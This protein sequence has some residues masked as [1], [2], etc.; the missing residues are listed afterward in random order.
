MRRTADIKLVSEPCVDREEHMARIAQ[1]E[2]DLHELKG[3]LNLSERR[4]Y[5]ADSRY[6]VQSGEF[7]SLKCSIAN[8]RLCSEETVQLLAN[9]FKDVDASIDDFIRHAAHVQK[10]D[11]DT[12]QD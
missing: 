5:V 4:K 1:S 9:A 6:S 11:Q 8:G 7:D 3:N 10:A 12:F 2:C